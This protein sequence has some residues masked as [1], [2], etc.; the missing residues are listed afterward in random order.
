M[1]QKRTDDNKPTNEWDT[2]NRVTALW[3]LPKTQITDEQYK[4]FYK[5]IAHD[6]EDPLAW[7]QHKVEGGNVEYTCLLYVPAH[8]T[9]DIW[10]R[11]A[12]HGLKL[13]VQRVFIMDQ[14]DQFMPHYL[15]FMRGVLDTTALSLNVSR[16]ILQDHPAIPKL[17]SALVRHTLDLLERLAKDEPEKYAIFW[18]AFG[19]VLKEGPAEDFSNREKI[20]KLL[21]FASTS[22]DEQN[23]SLDDYVSRMKENQKKIYYITADN[24]NAAKSS[25]HLEVFKKNNIEVLLLT[26]KIDEWVV[27]HLPE[28]DGKAFQSVAKGDLQ[29]D[30]LI[31]EDAE[32]KKEEEKKS[33]EQQ[34]EFDTV[35]K[36]VKEILKDKIQDVRL[37]HRLTSSPACLVRDQNALGPQMERLLKAAGQEVAPVKP[38]LELNP[39]HAIVKKLRD[40][41]K[42]QQLDEWTNILFEQALLAEGSQ[43]EDPAAFVQRINKLWMESL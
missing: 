4:E 30:E 8:A 6:F 41:L 37:S 14:V 42:Q 18:K 26:D 2:V 34:Q 5:H 10:Q 28:Y 36:S 9:H 15:R 35:L 27:G 11:D 17:R 25:P 23:I 16:E 20:A 21:R 24:I 43:L 13:Y 3:T 33:K 39:E 31:V 22:S 40:G 38:I 32:T 12:R 29:L 1:M 7:T 19:N